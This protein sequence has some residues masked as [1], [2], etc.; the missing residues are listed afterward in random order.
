MRQPSQGGGWAE[1]EAYKGEATVPTEDSH[2]E[3]VRGAGTR[4]QITRIVS[5]RTLAGTGEALIRRE[6]ES[7]MERQLGNGDGSG[8]AE[9]LLSDEVEAVRLP[10]LKGSRCVTPNGRGASIWPFFTA[11]CVRGKGLL[12]R[13][14]RY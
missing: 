5:F 13:R 1:N 8:H 3:S 11:A 12:K 10:V 14:G 7:Y 2:S 4:H 6:V 9:S